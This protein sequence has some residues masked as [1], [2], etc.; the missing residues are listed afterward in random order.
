LAQAVPAS[1]R[2]ARARPRARPCAHAPAPRPPAGRA[3]GP[4]GPRAVA[5]MAPAA[6]VPAM[7]LNV[8]DAPEVFLGTASQA[9]G[10]NRPGLESSCRKLHQEVH[11][12][13]A[14]AAGR[15]PS[16]EPCDLE[17]LF[18]TLEKALVRTVKHESSSSEQAIDTLLAL[19][20]AVPGAAAL[21]AP[22]E[23]SAETEGWTVVG[24]A[25]PPAVKPVL[26][27]DAFPALVDAD[28]WQVTSMQELDPSAS[29]GAGRGGTWSD[30]ARS[31]GAGAVAGVARRPAP[32]PR[33][34]D[35]GK[36]ARRPRPA[37]VVA[38][39]AAVKGKDS[40]AAFDESDIDDQAT[41][42]DVRQRLG[43]RRAAERARNGHGRR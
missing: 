4:P 11:E 40:T 39:G 19:A 13:W 41:D 18:P 31:A 42:Y 16:A 14:Q 33:G 10:A 35:M 8:S 28:G 43:H 27:P 6:A 30:L 7:Q 3:H 26:D 21:T 23:G 37:A 38:G 32:P 5:R 29:G 24:P 22:A 12:P 34:P 36:A 20:A 9:A 2:S 15:R 1:P 25:A 17:D